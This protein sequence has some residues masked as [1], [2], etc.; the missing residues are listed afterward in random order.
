MKVAVRASTLVLVPAYLAFLVTGCMSGDP[1]N[2]EPSREGGARGGASSG[3]GGG[4]GSAASGGQSGS[5]GKSSSGGSQG[6][7]GIAGSGGSTSTT[8]GS[9]GGGGRPGSG[10]IEAD[11]GKKTTGGSTG[12]GG[13][14]ATGGVTGGRGGTASSVAGTGGK[15]GAAGTTG[16]G[17]CSITVSSK[18]TSSKIATVG[19]VEWTTTLANVSKAQ[20]V[21]TLDKADSSILNTGG[22]A[23][24]DLTKAK[25]RT[26]LLGLKPSSTY[27]FHVEATSSSGAT[28]K[29]ED[30]TLTT[31]TL[32]GVPK[33]TRT[34]TK[35]TAQAK[36]FIVTSGGYNS[37]GPAVIIDADGQVVWSAAAPASCSRAHMSYEGTDMWMIALNPLNSNGEM[38]RISMDGLDIQNNVNGFS[39][40]HHDFTVLPGGIVA[41]LV[42]SSSGSDP[43]SDVLE[44]SA[45][46]TTKTALHVGSNLYAGGASVVGGGSNSYHANTII[47][48]PSDD[49][50]TIGD[51]NPSVFVKVTRGG[52]PVWQFGGSCTNAPAP[53]CA[54]GS[55]TSNHGHHLFEDGTFLFFNNGTYMSSSTP[56]KVFEFKLNTSGSTMSASQSK[57]YQS[58]SNSHSDTL[59]DVQRLPNGNTLVTFSNNGLIQELDSSW[60]V[61]QSL[62]ASSFGYADWRET[63]Y[64]GPPR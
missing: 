15:T 13:A 21:Y 38:R 32:S 27:T 17:E 40:A 46:G 22:T 58:S 29:S 9:S 51:R 64:G 47:Y 4:A 25:Y 63:L 3:K 16:T 10:G 45:D 54:S 44:R 5:G 34:A 48:Y 37:N 1:A 41:A 19:I 14:R 33:I 11:G 42:W 52:K 35:P 23:P 50:Y 53:K 60:N 20:I 30:N 26:L 8:G 43:Q 59:G 28:C 56:S 7:G 61:V 18:S 31:G 62:S 39:K 36:G 55:W 12:T 2:S 49:S 6:N 24:V 57:S